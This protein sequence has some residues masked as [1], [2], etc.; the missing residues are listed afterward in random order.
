MN[1]MM[2]VKNIKKS[3][4]DKVVLED[5]SFEINKG[6]LVAFLGNNGV[7]K[8][9]TLEII[10]GV[11]SIEYG[12]VEINNIGIK[13]IEFKKQYGLVVDNMDIFLN[14][15]GIEYLNLI[16]DLYRISK[17]KRKEK[18]EALSKQLGIYEDLKIKVKNYSKGMKQKLMIIG[19]LLHEPSVLILDEPFNGLDPKAIYIVKSLLRKYTNQGNAVLYS[20]HILDT[21]EHFSDRILILKSGKITYNLT[22]EEIE[23]E[24]INLEEIFF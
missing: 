1:N 3:Y 5:V 2:K 4:G 11:Q 10:T 14:L 8:T 13:D 6:E 15:K 22:M 19:E 24:N 18:I 9:T 23:K 16:A 20:T 7:G 21:V 17:E 12:N